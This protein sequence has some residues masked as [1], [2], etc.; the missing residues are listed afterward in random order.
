MSAD[1]GL[2][3]VYFGALKITNFVTNFNDFAFRLG[4]AV[5]GQVGFILQQGPTQSRRAES[6]LKPL[7]SLTIARTKISYT[8]VQQ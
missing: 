8:S 5:F 6:P 3:A 7:L 4:M 2:L 1:A